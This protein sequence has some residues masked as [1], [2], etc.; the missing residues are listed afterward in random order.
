MQQSSS[1]SR[2]LDSTMKGTSYIA[3][4]QSGTINGRSKQYMKRNP[5]RLSA[6]QNKQP[7][8]KH[9]S[10]IHDTPAIGKSFRSQ[11]KIKQNISAKIPTAVPFENDVVSTQRDFDR[12]FEEESNLYSPLSQKQVRDGE[13]ELYA[14]LYSKVPY[15]NEEDRRYAKRYQGDKGL[16]SDDSRSRSPRHEQKGPVRERSRFKDQIRR[17]SGDRERQRRQLEK[18]IDRS[19]TSSKRSAS[20]RSIRS[21]LSNRSSG[22]ARS[23]RA[24][25]SNRKY[26]EWNKENRAGRY[27]DGKS[28]SKSR[29]VSQ[30]S[31]RSNRHS[32]RSLRS[33]RSRDR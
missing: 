4:S 31:T 28:R 16:L 26:N 15:R 32:Y 29:G 19:M 21:K 14:P 25:M 30:K 5:S 18:S 7:L 13:R 1:Y 12:R 33:S 2:R 8:A 22:R 27:P 17:E 10:L 6:L 3:G 24:S 23:R 11:N 9:S 20:R